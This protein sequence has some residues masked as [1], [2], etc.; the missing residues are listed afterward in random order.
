MEEKIQISKFPAV[1]KTGLVPI[2]C[3]AIDYQAK[4]SILKDKFSYDLYNRIEFDWNI[5][6]KAIRI[7]DPILMAIRVRKFDQ[8]CRQFIEQHP[9][10][11]IVSLGSGV[12]NRFGRIDNNQCYFVDIDFPEVLEFKKII[13]PISMRN[14]LIGQSVLD[15]SWINQIKDI[16][17]EQHASV[18]FI[19]EGVMV[20]FEIPEIQG[21]LKK[22]HQAF[23]Q[24]E[25]FFD[26][27]SER[28][29][30]IAV[31]KSVFKDL[32]VKIKTGLNSGKLME[33]WGIGFKVLS[34]WYYSDDPDAKRGWMKLIWGIPHVRKLQY[35]VHGK[36][37]K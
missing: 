6:K 24:A 13:T 27:F 29:R 28:A 18:F 20:Y 12:D 30:K 19:A 17:I 4:N 2:Y 36:F 7:T 33:E 34:E 14:I 35:F 9:N 15:Y 5:V 22:I 37:K 10:G 11:I 23:P 21:L 8:M 32:N 16:S 26:M 1:S 25:I 3:R 31:R